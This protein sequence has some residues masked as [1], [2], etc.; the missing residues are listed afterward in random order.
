[1]LSYPD[2]LERKSFAAEF[3]DGHDIAPAA[4]LAVEHINNRSDLLTNYW[5]ELLQV[6]GGCTVTE[7]TTIGINNLAC[8]CKPIVGIIG[9]SC[10]TSA[11]FV[12]NL[13]GRDRFPMVTIHYGE[14]NILGS[15]E[16]FPFAFGMLGSNSNT[17]QAF[18]NLVI[19]NNWSKIVLLYSEDDLDLREV[20]TGIRKNIG[21][22]PGFDVAFVSPIYDYFIPLQEIKQS[23]ARVIIVLSSA[24]A[25][26]RILCLAFH[27]GVIFP[28]YQWV[29]KERY[30]EDFTE[31][32]F[33]YEKNYYVCTEDDISKSIYGSI[34]FV[35]SLSSDKR[36]KTV[37]DILASMEYEEGYKKQ[38]S[39]YMNEYNVSSVRVE[40]ARGIYD[41][42]WSLAF[43]LNSS[44]DE[45]NTNLTQVVPG[46][47]ILAQAIANRM[48]DIDFQGI[49]GRINFDSETGFNTAR[50]I[51]IYQ[52]GEAKYNTLIGFYT[53]K[54]LVILNDT[55]HQF[56][57]TTFDEMRVQISLAVAVPFLI[58]TV[59]LLLFAVPLQVINIIF[60]NKKIIKANSPNLN[61]LIFLG[62]Y[63]TVIGMVVYIII[64]IWQNT[65]TLLK[66]SCIAVP[67]FVNIGISMIVGTACLKTWRLYKLYRISKIARRLKDKTV[68]DP[69]LAAI[70]GALVFVDF[71]ICLIWTCVDPLISS[72]EVKIQA[73]QESNPPTVI[74]VTMVSC[75]SKWL[76]YWVCVQVGYKCILISCSTVL[77]MLTN[78]KIKE[79]Q[80]KNII[81][82]AYLLAIAFGLGIPMYVIVSIIDVDIS[83]HFAILCVVIDTVI[84]ISLF[85]L[86]LPSII[87]LVKRVLCQS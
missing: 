50:Q 69:V 5:V 19:K 63:L 38:R 49:S 82:L 14:R 17:I 12:G 36:N 56:I 16:I 85:A 68:S 29:F 75:Q 52:I 84:Y 46:S 73:S 34:N 43:A 2:P 6:D 41:A 60:R 37:D 77:A 45:L 8:I 27:E 72:T 39:L 87:P 74:I 30:E 58:T 83:V 51:E 76:V 24:R 65:Y 64:E 66:S 11:L 23:F 59:A 70:I 47:K 48:P 28:R 71:L 35:W 42:V 31:I 53:P 4:Y 61:H 55:T 9:P 21:D 22:T 62:C 33:S 18:T 15:R 26:L 1:M 40:W 54:E 67:W 7:R 10:G 32:S 3:D 78:I 79:F 80:T 86:F 25:T 57:R 44:L 13:T 20:C 81:I